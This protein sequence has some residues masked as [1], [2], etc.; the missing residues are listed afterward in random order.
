MQRNEKILDGEC[1]SVRRYERKNGWWKYWCYVD[2][3]EECEDA[4]DGWSFYACSR[5]I[6]IKDISQKICT[7]QGCPKSHI[8][9]NQTMDSEQNILSDECKDDDENHWLAEEDAINDDAEII[10]D[11]GCMKRV[12]GL[13]M[14]NIKRV[15]GGTKQFTVFLSEFHDGPWESILTDEFQEESP[16]GCGR[17]HLFGFR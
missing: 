4:Q 13:Q 10:I 9:H 14:K 15:Y 5:G 16:E 6:K 2:P 17:M 8:I 3:E 12:K 7:F 1:N 11:M